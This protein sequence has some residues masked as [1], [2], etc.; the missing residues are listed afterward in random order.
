MPTIPIHCKFRYE[1]AHSLPMVPPGHKCGNEH[2][3]SYHLTVTMKGPVRDD[4][5]VLDFAEVKEL[6]EPLIKQLDHHR[7]NDIPG[8]ENPTVE[9]QLVWLWHRIN[10][11]YLYELYLQETDN[12]SASYRGES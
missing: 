9:N 4:G 5:F 3:H 8:L 12:N 7:L 1:S 11:P 2:G 10:H 6:I